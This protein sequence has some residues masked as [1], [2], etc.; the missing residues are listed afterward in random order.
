MEGYNNDKESENVLNY[1]KFPS[2]RLLET[3][4][5]KFVVGQGDIL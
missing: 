2:K 1:L 3:F 4:F 5:Q